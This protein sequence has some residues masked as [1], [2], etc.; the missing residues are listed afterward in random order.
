[1]HFTKSLIALAACVLPLVTGAA[2]EKSELKI[3]NADATNTIENSYIVVGK[4]EVEHEAF[5]SEMSKFDV[6]SKRDSTFKGI[7]HKYSTKR[8][9][10]YQIETDPATLAEIAKS[11]K[12]SR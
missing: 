6:L 10:G 1:M 5:Y 2:I 8:F 7:G 11:D 3:R 12:V 4:D 9:K